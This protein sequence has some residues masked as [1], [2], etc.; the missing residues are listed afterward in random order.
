M[1]IFPVS[2]TTLQLGGAILAMRLPS[3]Q[4]YS[5]MTRLSFMDVVSSTPGETAA[6]AS[7][8]SL[9]PREAAP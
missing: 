3:E 2:L 5:I 9:I 7:V 1:S 4:Q 8:S 6:L